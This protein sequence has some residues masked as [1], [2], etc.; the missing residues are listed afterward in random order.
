MTSL[1]SRRNSAAAERFPVL[2]F[3]LLVRALK[4]DQLRGGAGAGCDRRRN[5]VEIIRG[6]GKAPRATENHQ[7][8]RSNDN[9]ATPKRGII[10]DVRPSW[11]NA[12]LPHARVDRKASLRGESFVPGPRLLDALQPGCPAW[13]KRGAAFVYRPGS[14]LSKSWVKHQSKQQG[15]TQSGRNRS[16]SSVRKQERPQGAAFLLTRPPLRAFRQA[17]VATACPRTAARYSATIGA[18]SPNARTLPSSI[19]SSRSLRERK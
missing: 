13:L 2:A 6:I 8:V 11:G 7:P 10:E 4:L 15:S 16:K 19:H 12:R 14:R 18:G 9:V 3:A 1:L 5:R 17:C